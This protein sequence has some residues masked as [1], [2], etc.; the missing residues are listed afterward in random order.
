MTVRPCIISLT[1]ILLLPLSAAAADQPLASADL[2]IRARTI[3]KNSCASCHVEK[4]ERSTLAILD[5]AQ[6]VR[7]GRTVSFVSPKDVAASQALELIESGSMPPGLLPKVSDADI[8][9]LRDWVE[10][11]AAA[12]PQQFDD[13]FAYRAIDAD[14]DRLEKGKKSDIPFMRYLTLH[15]LAA[16]GSTANLPFERAEFL[17][18]LE[19]LVKA[20]SP[21]PEPVDETA[22]IFRFDLRAAG[23]HRKPFLKLDLKLK[24]DGPADG[25]LFDVVLLEYPLAVVPK[26]SPTFDQIS[27]KFLKPAGQVRPIPFVRGDWFVAAVGSVP[28]ADE[29]RN[30]IEPMDPVPPGL[31]KPLP[32]GKPAAIPP[33]SAGSIAVPA[34][35][36]LYGPDPPTTAV[37]GLAVGTF[38]FSFNRPRPTF[39]PN[40]RLRLRV[41]AADEFFFEWVWMDFEKKIYTFKQLQKVPAGKTAETPLPEDDALGEDLGTERFFVFVSTLKFDPCERWRPAHG[42]KPVS[43]VVHPLYRLEKKGDLW[44]PSAEGEGLAR[45]TAS[46][47]IVARADK[48]K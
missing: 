10:R 31:L 6:M 13:E 14:L 9:I 30:L 29:L 7:T 48:K 35:D 16:D 4:S 37:K 23:W 3:L 22:T 1:A 15:H 26:Q 28:L 25:N 41:T 40:D 11:G 33:A 38:D 27:T 32:G 5:H 18:A 47:E 21:A 17:K 43:R 19:G 24:E 45:V 39:S 44:V 34:I 8:A 36:S 20:G 2:T 46:I 12:Y 42:I